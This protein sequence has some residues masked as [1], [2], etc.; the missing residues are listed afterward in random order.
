VNFA[1]AM[2]LK[3]GPGF[4]YGEIGSCDYAPGN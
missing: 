3:E 1:G 4:V 2:G